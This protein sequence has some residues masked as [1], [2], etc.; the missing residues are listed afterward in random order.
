MLNLYT[1]IDMLVPVHRLPENA[2][3]QH[4]EPHKRQ[5]DLPGKEDAADAW[6]HI[7]KGV[8]HAANDKVLKGAGDLDKGAAPLVGDEQPVA[9]EGVGEAEYYRIVNLNFSP[10][11]LAEMLISVLLNKGGS[12]LHRNGRHCSAV[13]RVPKRPTRRSSCGAR[14]TQKTR[15]SRYEMGPRIMIFLRCVWLGEI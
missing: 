7:G 4:A 9:E 6:R 1:H 12:D 3:P 13:A 11:L 14:K 2:M 8:P 15:Q 10:L 5:R